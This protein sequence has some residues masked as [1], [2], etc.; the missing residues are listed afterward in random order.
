MG[1]ADL[2]R[3]DIVATG[4]DGRE[5]WII[6]AGLGFPIEDEA[7]MITLFLLKLAALERHAA[8]QE[9]P[10]MLELVS[11][12]EP[13]MCVV[14]IMSRRGH[15]ATVGVDARDPA[16]GRSCDFDLDDDGWPDIDALQEANAIAFARAHGLPIPPQLDALDALD[17]V[18]AERRRS[19][20][21]DDDT[22][23][24]DF[25]DAALMVLAGAYAGETI[26]AEIRGNWRFDPRATM[27]QPIHLCTTDGSKVN[28]LGKV[29]K[30]LHYGSGDSVASL[31]GSVVHM[32][33]NG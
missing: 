26:R 19:H 20:D 23:D 3:I 13:P 11:V 7:L 31:A 17:D 15:R 25:T 27:L 33:R 10:P 32:A 8:H 9:K 2:D 28:V 5:R 24:E 6:V 30:F 14:R 16:C 29:K 18:L 22:T 4:D 1:L 21:L 12:D